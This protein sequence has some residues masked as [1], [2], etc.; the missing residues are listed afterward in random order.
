MS[1]SS[2]SHTQQRG[3]G[4][5]IARQRGLAMHGFVFA[6]VAID[7]L[8]LNLITNRTTIWA[9]WP[10]GVWAI[11]LAAH[12]GAT[13]VKPSAFGAHL[14]G[15]GAICLGLAVVN[16]FHGSWPWVIWP[17]LAWLLTLAIHA[18][19]AFDHLAHLRERRARR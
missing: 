5:A 1:P 11:V 4:R 6:V 19:F 16:L 7:L 2:P 13:L 8:V 12:A 14:A 15:G 18:P 10:I 17:I 3:I 9:V